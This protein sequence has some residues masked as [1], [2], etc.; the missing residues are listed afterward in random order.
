LIAI[1]YF[2]NTSIYIGAII[3]WKEYNFEVPLGYPAAKKYKAEIFSD[4]ASAYKRRVDFKLI[5]Y[6]VSSSEKLKIT[7]NQG[8]GWA[9]I[10]TPLNFIKNRAIWVQPFERKKRENF[11]E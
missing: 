9:T 6:N 1:E 11:F 10:L 5:T 4:G 3:Y 8:S 7:M 2:V